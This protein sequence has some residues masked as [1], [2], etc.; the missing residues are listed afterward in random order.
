M[1]IKYR[2]F[3]R[4]L[5]PLVRLFL[6]LKFGYRTEVAKK[7]PKNYLVL[8]NHVTDWDPLF[9]AAGFRR[10]MF[11]VASEHISR[12]KNAYRFLKFVFAP[13]LRKKGTVAS[14]TVVEILRKLRGG[15]NVCIFAEGARSWDGVTGPILPSTA[16]LVQSAKCGL[17]TYRIVGGYFV[18][19]NWSEKN[20][21]RGPI[22]G[23]V[24]GVYSAEKIAAMPLEELQALIERDLYED[25]YARQLADP[26]RYRCKRPAE[27]L[28]NLL[29]IC[30]QCGAQD[31]ISSRGDMVSCSACGLQFTCDEYG[32]LHGIDYTTVKELAAWQRG[33][34]E[35]GAE[36]GLVCRADGVRLVRVT[37]DG[38][39]L[40]AEDMAVMDARTLAC[41][42]WSV[43]LAEIT[44]LAMHGR[45]AVV[46]SV[47][48]EY[49][50]L[51]V[52]PG[53]NALKFHLLYQSLLR[54]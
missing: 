19:P 37:K 32:M 25:A 47:K 31:T 13:I 3:Y 14:S 11:F 50:E 46:F 1:R 34:V 53:A 35:A 5:R 36:N 20:L 7:L 40:V 39:E 28:E 27:Q 42:E 21:R 43:P 12:W 18:S 9:V 15:E 49:F 22:R 17:V 8:A 29:F 45:R 2:F 54:K 23:A 44:D 52:A 4:L 6:W 26:K 10:Q 33:A 51:L 38:E 41:G 24:A 48:K 30:P 16:K